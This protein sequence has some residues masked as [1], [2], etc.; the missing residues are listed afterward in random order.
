MSTATEATQNFQFMNWTVDNNG[1][2]DYADTRGFTFAAMFEYHDRHWAA[3]FAE[4]LMPKVANGIHLD[5]D[6]A[7]AH[8]ENM[9]LEIHRAV[10]PKR[11]GI[12]RLLAYVN[13]ANMGSYR[14]AIDNFRAGLTPVPEITAH[15]LQTTIKY[16]FGANFEQPFNDWLGLFGRWGW[17]EGPPRVL[18]VHRSRRNRLTRPR[19]QWRALEPEIR[20]RRRS[21]RLQRHLARP[22]AIPCIRRSWLSFGRRPPQLRPRKYHRNLLHTACLARCLSLVRTSVCGP[23]G[24][25]SRPRPCPGADVALAL[26]VLSSRAAWGE[27]FLTLPDPS[28]ERPDCVHL[29]SQRHNERACPTNQ[30]SPRKKFLG[31][32]QKF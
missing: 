13:H 22:S 30:A 15:P 23:S 8:S 19:R 11:E 27:A 3:R 16:G 2:Y 32:C 20:S 31:V 6:L 14:D 12:L 18:R 9:E 21:F 10:I 4:G 26:G 24:L 28:S 25:Q 7:R 29:L 17:N 5:A 1:A